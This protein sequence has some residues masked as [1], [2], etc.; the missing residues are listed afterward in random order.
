MYWFYNNNVVYLLPTFIYYPYP[1]M[2]Y[3]IVDIYNIST[4]AIYDPTPILPFHYIPMLYT[5]STLV[6]VILGIPYYNKVYLNAELSTS[7]TL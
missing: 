1:Y 5:L 2:V 6:N 4:D 7:I 3:T